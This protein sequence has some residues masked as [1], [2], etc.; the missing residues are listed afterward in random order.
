[1][2]HRAS[3]AFNLSLSG[4]EGKEIDEQCGSLVGDVKDREGHGEAMALV[5]EAKEIADPAGL[6]ELKTS[7]RT[8]HWLSRGAVSGA[9]SSQTIGWRT[10]DCAMATTSLKSSSSKKK[11]LNRPLALVILGSA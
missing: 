1:M 8:R 2:V 5:V 3:A 9:L 7:K 11:H 4:V 10:M 6:Q